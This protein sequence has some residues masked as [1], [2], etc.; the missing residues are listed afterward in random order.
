[1]KLFFVIFI[2][3][4]A[5]I[6]LGCK[7]K[8]MKTEK[9]EAKDIKRFSEITEK[10]FSYL[11][12]DTNIG[13]VLC[14]RR[15]SIFDIC[16]DDDLTYALLGTSNTVEAIQKKYNYMFKVEG[17]KLKTQN[18]NR[19]EV[20]M[21]LSYQNSYLELYY[22][23]VTKTNDI[24]SACIKDREITM[25]NGLHVGMLKQKFFN[26][27]FNNSSLYNFESVKEFRNGDET[28]HIN[29]VFEFNCDTLSK[30][31]ISSD[32]IWDLLD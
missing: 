32:Y 9:F 10:E 30:V 12:K 18:E 27:L 21:K 22:N 16:S 4:S 2:F 3:I 8:K 7:T 13:R 19:T 20:I 31:I 17:Q 1:M 28:G 23:H 29:Q 11:I 5:A 14:I 6:Y 15:D 25:F 24:V 26:K